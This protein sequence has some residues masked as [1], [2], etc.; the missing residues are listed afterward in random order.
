MQNQ[1][2]DRPKPESLLTRSLRAN[3][4]L[5]PVTIEQVKFLEENRKELFENSPQN[6]TS[7]E[8][9]L[10]RGFMSLQPLSPTAANADFEHRLA[11][12]A[13]EGKAI[14]EEI[15]KR[16]VQDRQQSQPSSNDHDTTG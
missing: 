1:A 11:Q 10:S 12:A 4:L 16:M 6:I 8:E 9:I 14:P 3:G 13:R 2:D 15:R 7:A 5:F